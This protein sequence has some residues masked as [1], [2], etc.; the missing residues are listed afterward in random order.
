MILLQA[1][2]SFYAGKVEK[3]KPSTDFIQ[4]N[5]RRFCDLLVSIEVTLSL[6]TSKDA[7]FFM[8]QLLYI[9]VTK[10]ILTGKGTFFSLNV[11]QATH[12]TNIVKCKEISSKSIMKSKYYYFSVLVK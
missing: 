7:S 10:S 6:K 1:L 12:L 3:K 8:F 11:L 4:S 9:V 2:T 5:I